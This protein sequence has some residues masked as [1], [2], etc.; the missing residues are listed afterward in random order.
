M[1]QY[2]F[3]CEQ[4]LPISIEQAWNFFSDP[5]NLCKIT[6]ASLDFKI[7][8]AVPAKIYD[9]LE[10]EYRVRPLLGIRLPWISRIHDVREPFQFVDV[11]LRGPYRY[12]HHQ[13]TFESISTG[14]LMKDI[15]TYEVPLASIFP[16]VNDWV[17]KKELE[18][19]FNFRYETLK[20]LFG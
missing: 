6:P 15:I 12:W 17:V 2:L 14:V 18:R 19:I 10:I 5:R 3:Q 20:S 1:P 4:T 7:I 16:W 8:S 9:G 11:Q 13:H